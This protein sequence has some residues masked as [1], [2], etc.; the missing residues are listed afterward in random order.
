M[1]LAKFLG[2]VEDGYGKYPTVPYHNHLHGADVLHTTFSLLQNE[3]LDGVFS[4]LE[5][6]SKIPFLSSFSGFFVLLILPFVL[7]LLLFILLL[8]LPALVFLSVLDGLVLIC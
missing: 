4:D 7:P 6:R 2:A 8:L 3:A 1:Q 5:V